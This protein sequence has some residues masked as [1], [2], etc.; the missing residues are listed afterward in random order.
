MRLTRRLL[1]LSNQ[2]LIWSSRCGAAEANPTRNHEV[3]GSILAQW[4]EDLALPWAVVY[5]TNAAQIWCC[6]G[7]GAGR[8]QQLQLDP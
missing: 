2:K 6:C 7:S 5:V 1:N 3:V 8:W 4:V